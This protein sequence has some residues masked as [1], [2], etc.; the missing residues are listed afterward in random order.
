LRSRSITGKPARQLK[1]A[2]TDA[3]DGP[4]SPGP[5]PMPLQPLLVDYALHR[6]NRAA[7]AGAPG[8][9]QLVNDFVGQVV[10]SLDAVRPARQVLHEMIEEYVDVVTAQAEGLRR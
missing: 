7:A 1:S 2:W 6:I 10:G 4:N 5:L 3:W 8:A 9:V